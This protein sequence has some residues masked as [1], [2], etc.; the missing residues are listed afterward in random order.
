MVNEESLV[1]EQE[2]KQSTPVMLGI[3]DR[4]IIVREREVL[5]KES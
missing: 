3:E 4:K 5:H 1:F 2:I